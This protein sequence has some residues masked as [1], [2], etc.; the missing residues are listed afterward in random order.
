[1]TTSAD[2]PNGAG[3]PVAPVLTT[4]LTFL[5]RPF[6]HHVVI[7][8]AGVWTGSGPLTYAY[9]WQ[10]QVGKSFINIKGATRSA[11]RLTGK[12]HKIRAVVTVTGPGG[13]TVAI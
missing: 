2:N 3:L 4:K 5:G 1:M 7:V 9:Q 13:Q 6:L 12:D 8:N 11:Y 10:R